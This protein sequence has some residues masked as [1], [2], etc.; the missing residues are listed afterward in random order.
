MVGAPSGIQ[1]VNPF[2]EGKLLSPAVAVLVMIAW[3]AI[4]FAATAAMLRRRDLV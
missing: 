3:V 1:G 4:A 2:D